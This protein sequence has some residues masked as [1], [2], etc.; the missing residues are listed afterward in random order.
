MDPTYQL[1]E[2]F[3]IIEFGEVSMGSSHFPPLLKVGC[4]WNG[5]I[6]HAVND[7][8]FSF[9]EETWDWTSVVKWNEIFGKSVFHSTRFTIFLC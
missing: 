3:K 4:V 5:K 9:Q 6:P 8:Y 7:K 1:L 2:T